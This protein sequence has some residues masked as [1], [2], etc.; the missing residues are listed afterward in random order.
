[1]KLLLLLQ[2]APSQICFLT[3]L[4]IFAPSQQRASGILQPSVMHYFQDFAQMRATGVPDNLESNLRWKKWLFQQDQEWGW[5]WCYLPARST[6]K[7]WPRPCCHPHS[8]PLRI[9]KLGHKCLSTKEHLCPQHERRWFYCGQSG[10]RLV[11]TKLTEES[12]YAESKY[13]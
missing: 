7:S 4:Q 1:M 12:A 9:V 13:H 6:A 10:I 11:L 2:T 3:M 5:L 8:I